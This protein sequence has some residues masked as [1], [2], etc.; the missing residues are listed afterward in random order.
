VFNV[1][2]MLWW[3][4]GIGSCSIFQCLEL[5]FVLGRCFFTWIRVCCKRVCTVLASCNIN[6]FP[7]TKK[8]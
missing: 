3:V 8:A 2:S 4:H 7:F 1:L 6:P 5:L